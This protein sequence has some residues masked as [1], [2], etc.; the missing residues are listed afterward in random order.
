MKHHAVYS[1]LIAIA[2]VGVSPIHAQMT[3]PNAPDA[4]PSDI[5][6][7][8]TRQSGI[9]AAESAAPIK[10]VGQ[11]MIQHVGQPNLNQILAQLVPSFRAS[12]FGSDAANL[13]ISGSL[14][15]LNPNHTLVLVNGK[16]RHGTANLQVGSSPGVLR[17]GITNELN[18]CALDI[19]PR[20]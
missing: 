13:S 14:R 5:I 20:R 17:E 11:E 16:R 19:Q 18:E 9:S 10:L 4:E 7:T 2:T 8:G 6:V 12:S 3:A 15:G 1:S